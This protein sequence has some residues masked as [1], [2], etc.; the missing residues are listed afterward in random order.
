MRLRAR[1][2]AHE[3]DRVRAPGAAVG[4]AVGAEHERGGGVREQ[5]AA[6]RERGARAGVDALVGVVQ[7]AAELPVAVA[8]PEHE[9]EQ[10]AEHRERD[11]A[12]QRRSRAA[13]AAAAA[14]ARGAPSVDGRPSGRPAPAA[15]AACCSSGQ[16]DDARPARGFAGAA[17]AS[18][19]L[20]VVPSAARRGRSAAARRRR[21]LAGR[22]GARALLDRVLGVVAPAAI[23]RNGRLASSPTGLDRRPRH[24]R[25]APR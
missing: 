9:Q 3:Q 21:R 15:P 16:H 6:G 24:R 1:V 2:D 14:G 11:Q 12:P 8:D 10:D 23:V 5:R 4:A 18:A 22:T 25:P 20:R 17:E 19:R 13:R 7:R